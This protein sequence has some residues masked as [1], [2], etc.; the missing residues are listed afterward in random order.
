[1]I[2]IP[3]SRDARWFS[4]RA[5]FARPRVPLESVIGTA[6]SPIGKL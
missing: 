2:Q 5:L 4:P 3:G 1:M 6:E